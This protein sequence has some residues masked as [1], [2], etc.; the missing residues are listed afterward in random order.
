LNVEP[1][2]YRFRLLD[3]SIS[4]TFQLYLQ[5][6]ST[7]KKINFQVI[8]SDTGL[9]SKPITTDNIYLSMAER[10]EIIVDFSTFKG[11][12]VDLLN[13][14]DVGADEDYA[15]TD[16]VMRFNVGNTVTDSSNNGP[17]PSPL[18]TLPFPPSKTNV[19]R[20]FTFA[21]HNGEWQIN[22]ATFA[23]IKNRIIAKPVRGALEV[24]EL[25]NK[26]GGWSHPVHIH[27]IDFRIISRTDGKRGVMPYESEAL[28][29]VVWLGPNEKVKVLARYAPWDGVYSK[30]PASRYS[31]RFN[32]NSIPV[33]HCHNLIHEDH[34]MMGAF[35]VTSLENFGYTDKTKFLDPMEDRW[36]AKP[37]PPPSNSTVMAKLKMF[38]ELDA[39][40]HVKEAE[41][42]LERYYSTKT[43]NKV[44]RNASPTPP[45]LARPRLLTRHQRS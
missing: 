20:T 21:R 14:R 35:N 15:A 24:W 34:D 23:D 4:R 43:L 39:Y 25:E 9:I 8:G 2:K 6:V 10:W 31:Y 32:A 37:Y 26:S 13:M 36:R 42:A 30:F 17:V 29:D 7:K 33:F 12:S 38:G 19:D 16:K 5:S 40:S 41:E 3:S 11:Q 44:K 1:R 27:L 28:K 18:R 45:P 22:G